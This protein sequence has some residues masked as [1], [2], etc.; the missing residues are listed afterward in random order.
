VEAVPAH[1][2]RESSLPS[3]YAA[4]VARSLGWTSAV[5]GGLAL[6]L[7]L[8]DPPRAKLWVQAPARAGGEA[9]CPPGTLEDH[10][11]CIP[12]PAVDHALDEDFVP[13]LPDRP[14]KFEAYALPID[15]EARAGALEDAPLPARFR[16]GG[17]ALALRTSSPTP[18]EAED[19]RAFGATR[20]TELDRGGGWL[21]V[22]SETPTGGTAPPFRVVLSGLSDFR[23]EARPGATLPEAGVLATVSST[24][25]ISARQLRPGADDSGNGW[26]QASSVAVDIRNVL[27]LRAP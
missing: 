18:L 26:E 3:L 17:T 21:V 7:L 6:V 15:G 22:A 14:E 5:L 20:I 8:T 11:V 24:L 9:T 25:W 10:K 12:V 27:R 19:L 2:S 4:T 13:R 16:L 1:E 23:P